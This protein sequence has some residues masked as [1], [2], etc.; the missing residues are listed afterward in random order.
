MA[1]DTTNEKLALINSGDVWSDHLPIS[2]AGIGQDDKQQLLGSYPG[3]LWGADEPAPESPLRFMITRGIGFAPTQVGFIV[4]H[5]LYAGPDDR[6]GLILQP[7]PYWDK[8]YT[9][10]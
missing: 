5:G 10:A 6:E 2:S 1:I 8:R 3:T 4:T 9:V 7:V